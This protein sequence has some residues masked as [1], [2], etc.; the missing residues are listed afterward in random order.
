MAY[1]DDIDVWTDVVDNVDVIRAWHINEAHKRII[2]IEQEL[3]INPSGTET[4]LVARLE[5]IINYIENHKNRHEDGGG[6]EISVQGLLGQLAEP[7]NADRIR[8]VE[9]DD[10]GLADGK[11]LGYVAATGKLEYI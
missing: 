4:D 2:A 10:S 1:P 6:D 9:V 8:G 3:G 5:A 7:Q 11:V